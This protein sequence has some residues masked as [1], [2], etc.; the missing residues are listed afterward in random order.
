MLAK[1]IVHG[2]TREAA[3]HALVTA[4]DDTAILGLTTNLGF[5]RAL[6]DSAEFRDGEVD[7]AWLDTHP[8]AIRPAGV[9]SAWFMAAWALATGAGSHEA[10]ENNPPFGLA[11]GW[12]L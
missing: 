3:R 7:T 11:D 8:D 12:R 10:H 1:V 4:L 6:A 9:E 5:L 2:P